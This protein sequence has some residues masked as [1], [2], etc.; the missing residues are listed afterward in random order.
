MTARPIPSAKPT[1][2]QSDRVLARAV[3]PF[4]RFLHVEAAGGI[5]L[6]L[7]PSSRSSGR[8]R[9]GRQL[10]ALL[11]HERSAS[12]SVRTCSTHDL[13]PLSSTTC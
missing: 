10:R 8:T 2:L 7:A 4:V 6:V 13:A 3:R 11:A 1:F 9:P 12:R 5:L